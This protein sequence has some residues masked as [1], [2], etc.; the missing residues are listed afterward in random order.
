[1]KCFSHVFH[2]DSLSVRLLDACRTKA[3][4]LELL[5]AVCLVRGGH[6]IILSAFDNFKEVTKSPFKRFTAVCRNIQLF[7]DE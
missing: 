6:E 2:A 7:M 4:V 5:A 1:M 3:L